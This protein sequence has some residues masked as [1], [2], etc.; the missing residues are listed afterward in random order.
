MSDEQEQQ[1]DLAREAAKANGAAPERQVLAADTAFVV[2][3]QDGMAYATNDLGDVEVTVDNRTFFVEAMRKASP[4][5]LYRYSM[6]VAKDVQVS[7]TAAASA[8]QIFEITKQLQAQAQSQAGG[9]H[10]PGR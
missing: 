6:E 2:F 5:D 9:L 4:D 1:E 10:V 7:Q 3:V 8:M